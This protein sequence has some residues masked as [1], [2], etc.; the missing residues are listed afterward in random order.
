MIVLY[1][2]V[3]NDLLH[4]SQ[5]LSSIIFNTFLKISIFIGFIE[6]SYYN[7]NNNKFQ[8]PYMERFSLFKEYTYIMV[9]KYILKSDNIHDS[10]TMSKSFEK[11]FAWKLFI[12]SSRD[13][14][15]KFDQ[16]VNFEIIQISKHYL[17]IQKYNTVWLSI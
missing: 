6:T 16:S 7:S 17:H 15:L 14:F 11:Y 4:L 9:L 10:C 3:N 13:R 12:R 2:I 5:I 1:L 8:I